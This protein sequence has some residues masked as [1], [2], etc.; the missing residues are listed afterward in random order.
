VAGGQACCVLCNVQGSCGLSPCLQF[1][2]FAQVAVPEGLQKRDQIDLPAVGADVCL[3]GRVAVKP[4]E[5]VPSA[6]RVP[7]VVVEVSG[8]T[9]KLVHLFLTLWA[10][11][12]CFLEPNLL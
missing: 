9:L 7:V 11:T 2:L 4:S 1:Q 12:V 6:G 8:V 3:W 10:G 5:I